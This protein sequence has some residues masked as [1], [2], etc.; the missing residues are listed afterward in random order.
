MFT[1]YSKDHEV[2]LCKCVL[3]FRSEGNPESVFEQKA[4]KKRSKLIL[5]T[6]QISD[7]EM[8]EIVK[9]GQATDTV[10]EFSDSN[11]TRFIAI[12]S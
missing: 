1:K 5:P 12:F 6:P 7:K 11:P 10:R 3:I 8:E 2:V 9:I 4:E